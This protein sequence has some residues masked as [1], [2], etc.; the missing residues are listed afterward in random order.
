MS[1]S[2]RL[3]GG[4]QLSKQ[5]A[6]LSAAVRTSIPLNTLKAGGLVV[7]SAARD[8]LKSRGLWE[9]GRLAGSVTTEIEL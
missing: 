9:T 8:N 1:I 3:T 6:S 7:E 2:Y 4:P 5:L